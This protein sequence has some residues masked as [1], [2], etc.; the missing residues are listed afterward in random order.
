MTLVSVTPS[1]KVSIT[2]NPAIVA[3]VSEYT[4]FFQPHFTFSDAY[5]ASPEITPPVIK[6][7]ITVFAIALSNTMEKATTFPYL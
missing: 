5:T 7:N 2:T 4:N 1:S 3:T 6:A